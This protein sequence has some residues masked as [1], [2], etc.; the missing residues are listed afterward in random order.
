L[1]LLNEFSEY[2]SEVDEESLQM[3]NF[4]WQLS[5]NLNKT[6]LEQNLFGLYIRR[7]SS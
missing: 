1:G 3:R 4:L 2:T 7:A 5:K 6:K